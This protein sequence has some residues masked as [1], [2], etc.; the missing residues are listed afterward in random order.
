MLKY[1]SAHVG[2][3]VALLCASPAAAAEHLVTAT[4]TT[5][6]PVNE[7]TVKLKDTIIILNVTKS[8]LNCRI[9]ND[10]IFRSFTTK[11]MASF[12]P[13]ASRVFEVMS[14]NVG[15]TN[16]NCNYMKIKIT[17]LK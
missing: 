9:D 7:I 5:S 15:V 13:Q 2:I 14:V 16:I 11:T 10:V 12:D 3:V 8:K 6:I 17:A 4:D 1:V